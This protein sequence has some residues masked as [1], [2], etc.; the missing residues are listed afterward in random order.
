LRFLLTFPFQILFRCGEAGLRFIGFMVGFCFRLLR[1]MTGN[2][3]VLLIGAL[4]GV[5][6]GRRKGLCGGQF[7]KRE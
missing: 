1:F 6:L 2:I 5:L 4:I 3:F 7:G